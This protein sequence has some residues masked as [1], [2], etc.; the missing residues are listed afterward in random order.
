MEKVVIDA[1]V[2]VKWFVTEKDSDKALKLRDSY[3]RGNFELV[4]PTLIYYEVLNALRFHPHY[5]LTEAELLNVVAA[6]RGMQIVTETTTEMWF[7]AFEVS[8]S[9]NITVYDAVYI[10]ISLVLDTKIVTSDKRLAER[11]DDNIK[12]KIKLLGELSL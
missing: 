7:R 3:Q 5:K 2:A 10:G 4:A 12:K 1:S 11:L 6:L 9:Q 8:I